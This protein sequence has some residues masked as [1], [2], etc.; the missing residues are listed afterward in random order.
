MKIKSLFLTILIAT[1]TM[2]S[3]QKDDRGVDN[4][5]SKVGYMSVSVRVANSKA[6]GDK[7]SGTEG[8][9]KISNATLFIVNVTGS[10]STL[11]TTT[12]LT[13]TGGVAEK[14][15]TTPGT[16]NVYVIVNTT[17]EIDAIN[18]G[19]TEEAFKTILV[20]A[21]SSEIA[22]NNK[23]VMVGV[24]PGVTITAVDKP[25][26]LIVPTPV[27][28]TVSRVVA[29]AV[30]AINENTMKA[31]ASSPG[32]FSAPKFMI[33][34][35]TKQRFLTNATSTTPSNGE[36]AGTFSN[37][38]SYTLEEFAT[39]SKP[40]LVTVGP[41]ETPHV[42]NYTEDYSDYSGENIND[43]ALEGNTSF[44]SICL[45]YKPASSEYIGGGSSE[46]LTFFTVP[47]GGN[48]SHFY[49]TS[50][51]AKDDDKAGA[52]GANILEYTD[53]KCYYR[54][55]IKGSDNIFQVLP[56]SL[57]KIDINKINSIGSSIPDTGGGDKPIEIGKEI[58]ATITVADWN[59]I[60]VSEPI[61]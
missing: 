61:G 32:E 1:T 3:C 52:D 24:T 45:V 23:F 29:K 42:W 44:I 22:L 2:L 50:T 55:N 40:I 48:V 37:I 58:E 7:I 17:A 15:F 19:I 8:E 34:N 56:N 13:L 16:K 18:T 54:L 43:I 41:L 10:G 6:T 51:L 39:N 9:T 46:G 12:K 30:V 14:V 49:R 60:E 4:S 31:T 27:A 26:D 21:K 28:V 57:Y 53:G 47:Q 25:G 20:S 35:T 36:V 59:A 33:G 5:D 11:E 38:S